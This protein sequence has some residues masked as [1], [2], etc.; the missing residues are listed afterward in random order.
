MTE[1]VVLL[2][3]DKLGYVD[4][5][6]MKWLGM[7]LSDHTEALKKMKAEDQQVDILPKEEMTTE[8]ISTIL[9]EAYVTKSPVSIQANVL[10]DGQ[11]YPDV[12]CLVM[13]Y[14]G[15]KII[16]Q[17]KDGRIKRVNIEL[18]RHIDL[19]NVLKWHNKRTPSD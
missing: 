19:Y 7:M 14:L 5:G 9:Y 8:D 10:K 3:P 18:I 17:L 6:K 13:G 16:L 11:Y 4:R 12:E 2:D 15:E 1:E